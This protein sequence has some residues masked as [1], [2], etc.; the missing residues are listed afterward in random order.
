[1]G[2]RAQQEVPLEAEQD[3]KGK[4][5]LVVQRNIFLNLPVS[6]LFTEFIVF[7]FGFV[8]QAVH[9][10]VKPSLIA[11]LA[12]GFHVKR[13]VDFVAETFQFIGQITGIYVGTAD[14]RFVFLFAQHV[15]IIGKSPE[16]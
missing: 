9:G 4:L 12:V 1:M 13:T 6:R 8:D 15:S 10:V 16:I 2:L 11:V 3:L 5:F 7:G 14:A